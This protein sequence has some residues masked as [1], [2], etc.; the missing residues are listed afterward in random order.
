M[1][2]DFSKR[3]FRSSAP[4]VWNS[5]PKTVLISDSLAVFKSRLKTVLFNQIFT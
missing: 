5:V 4:T 2:T 3:A 1:R